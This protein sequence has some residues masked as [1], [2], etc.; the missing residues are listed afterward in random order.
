MLRSASAVAALPPVAWTSASVWEPGPAASISKRPG[1][2]STEPPAPSP[3][4][5]T[6]VAPASEPSGAI[7]KASVVG[8]GVT[9]AW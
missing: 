1:T 7:S 5:A 2:K 6:R 9:S 4:D 8:V 3:D